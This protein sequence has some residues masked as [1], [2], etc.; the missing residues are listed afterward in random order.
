[1]IFDSVRIQK[2]FYLIPFSNSKKISTPVLYVIICWVIWRVDHFLEVLR[3][4]TN[5]RNG[6]IYQLAVLLYVPF[7]MFGAPHR[8]RLVSIERKNQRGEKYR[9]QFSRRLLFYDLVYTLR[10]YPNEKRIW[11]LKSHLFIKTI[12]IFILSNFKIDNTH[13]LNFYSCL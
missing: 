9:R 1:M 8:M 2:I 12:K 5:R 7:W 4:N 11:W 3:N 6:R 10:C 13:N